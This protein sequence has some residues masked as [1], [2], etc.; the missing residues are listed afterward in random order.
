[1]TLIAGDDSATTY[2]THDPRD[3]A[4]I[5]DHALED[6]G[7]VEERVAVAHRAATWWAAQGFDG[8]RRV[9]LAWKGAIARGAADLAAVI[10]L[11]PLSAY[12]RLSGG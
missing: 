7:R 2:S 11:A 12:S 10:S 8:R 5:A 3:G 6:A 9:L 1:M 4:L